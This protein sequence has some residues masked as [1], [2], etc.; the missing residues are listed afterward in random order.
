MT[1][2]AEGLLSRVWPSQGQ[3]PEFLT[4][5]R[6]LWVLH[7]VRPQAGLLQ[8]PPDLVSLVAKSSSQ[9][10]HLLLVSLHL[11]QQMTAPSAAR[12]WSTAM[13]KS[14]TKR[15]RNRALESSDWTG[16]P[17]TAR[18]SAAAQ[19][20]VCSPPLSKMALGMRH[21]LVARACLV[22]ALQQASARMMGLR[23]EVSNFAKEISW[24]C[25]PNCA[26][27]AAFSA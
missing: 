27:L 21:N 11:A 17:Q 10:R 4:C 18:P 19:T 7:C 6:A 20:A 2:K 14:R 12:S 22:L 9:R 1:G 16:E 23:I 24:V 8:G 25:S 13:L 5:G 15:K 26:L 3:C